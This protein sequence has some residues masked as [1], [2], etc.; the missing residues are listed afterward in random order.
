MP[1]LALPE[2]L[3]SAAI[4]LGLHILRAGGLRRGSG[5]LSAWSLG[6]APRCHEIDIWRESSLR[7]IRLYDGFIKEGEEAK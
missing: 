3:R 4:G 5:F 6:H 1:D 7:E 2:L